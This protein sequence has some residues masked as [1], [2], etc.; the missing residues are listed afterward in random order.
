MTARGEQLSCK[1]PHQLRYKYLI[2]LLTGLT[3]VVVAVRVAW[4]T[5]P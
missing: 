1:V 5:L 2:L 3:F 4:V